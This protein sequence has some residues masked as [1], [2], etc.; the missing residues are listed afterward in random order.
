MN[1]VKIE[2][3]DL[4]ERLRITE[5]TNAIWNYVY[6]DAIYVFKIE[7]LRL[8]L[9]YYQKNNGKGFRTSLVVWTGKQAY[10][11]L[12]AKFTFADKWRP[13][14][15]DF[16]KVIDY[17]PRS[18]DEKNIEKMHPFFTRRYIWHWS[19]VHDG[20]VY[21]VKFSNY[22]PEYRESQIVI[23]HG[24]RT[25]WSAEWDKGLSVQNSSSEERK[26]I[27][28]CIALGRLDELRMCELL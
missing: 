7:R 5:F 28:E 6:K 8:V 23:K 22:Y 18:Y 26:H 16:C 27:F 14:F 12:E 19:T 13:D 25:G 2:D 20:F 15:L 9:R 11:L 10:S 1:V 21:T 4:T 24:F 17:I 3:F